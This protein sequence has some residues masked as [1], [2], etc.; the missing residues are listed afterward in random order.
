MIN[1]RCCICG[2]LADLHHVQSVGSQGYRDKI[3]HIG[4]EAL[5]LCREHH[6]LLHS[7]GNKKFMETY[8]LQAVEIDKKIA[9]V[10]GL[11]TKEK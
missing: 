6:T 9:K 10:Y 8:H 11:N 7:M 2:K 4:L 5:P 1:K 3:N